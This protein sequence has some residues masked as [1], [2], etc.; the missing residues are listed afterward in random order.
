MV[1]E[2]IIRQRI[3]ELRQWRDEHVARRGR[4]SNIDATVCGLCIA[5]LELILRKVE[6]WNARQ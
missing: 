5:E 1:M 6:S 3:V 4:R 2:A